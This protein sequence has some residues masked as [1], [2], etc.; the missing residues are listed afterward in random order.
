VTVSF[1]IPKPKG[2]VPHVPSHRSALKG[3][4]IALKRKRIVEAAR[5]LFYEK[6]YERTTLDALR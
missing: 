4:V 3:E 6:G 1:D 5:R 2:D